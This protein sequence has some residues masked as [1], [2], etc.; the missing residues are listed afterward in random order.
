M[1][2]L[3]PA[4]KSFIPTSF[5]GFDYDDGES[6]SGAKYAKFDAAK[7]DHLHTREGALTNLGP[8]VVANIFP[9]NLKWEGKKVVDR[10]LPT[11]GQKLPDVDEEN[12]KIPV[13]DWEEDLNG[14]SKGPWVRNYTLHLVDPITGAKLIVSNS[15][16]GMRMAYGEVKEGTKVIRRMRG[17]SVFPV[18]MLGE[19]QFTTNFGTRLR[20]QFKIVE[21][22]QF[23]GDS[24]PAIAAPIT[25]PPALPG[26]AVEKP[27]S[28]EI[29]DD[30][31]PDRPVGKVKSAKAA[32]V[33]DPDDDLPF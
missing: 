22:R 30:S 9:E 33:A 26:K 23:G 13:E 25:S 24:A 31:I 5:D 14:N 16:V 17:E 20:P 6:P 11:P 29:V 19:E 12:A 27:T 15:T 7:K 1:S 10:M 18:V 21:Y 28:A 3:V 4:N 8:Y 2:N 32:K